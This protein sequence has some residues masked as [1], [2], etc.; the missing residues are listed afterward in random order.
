MLSMKEVHFYNKLVEKGLA[1]KLE[2]SFNAERV[3]SHIIIPELDK[4]D[5]LL[6]ICLTCNST[7]KLGI[8][9]QETIKSYINKYSNLTQ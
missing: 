6:F 7:F 2:C 5:E 1:S 3:G 4:N 8:N 9:T